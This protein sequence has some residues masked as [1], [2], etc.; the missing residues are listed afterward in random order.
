MKTLAESDWELDP[1]MRGMKISVSF[2]CPSEL[3][4]VIEEFRKAKRM[5]NS[6]A[7]TR[8]TRLGI[9][10]LKL[11]EEQA[12]LRKAESIVSPEKKK[13]KPKTSSK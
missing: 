10:Y 1:L 13:P 11:L 5:N 9:T 7:I 12:A 2:S 8:L 6:Q 4:F 3:L